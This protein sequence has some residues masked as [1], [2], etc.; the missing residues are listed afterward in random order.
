MSNDVIN[1]SLIK[2]SKILKVNRYKIGIV[3][4]VIP[5]QLEFNKSVFTRS[6]DAI[7]EETVKLNKMKVKTIIAVGYS[8]TELDKLIAYQCP[9]VDL[10]ICGNLNIL[11]MNTSKEDTISVNKA[12]TQIIKQ[13]NG[14][15]VPLV[16]TCCRTKYMGNVTIFIDTKTG[17]IHS[18]KGEQLLLNGP[19]S[20]INVSKITNYIESKFLSKV[21]ATEV[22]KERAEELVGETKTKLEARRE[23]CKRQE[24][25]F[26]SLLADSLIYHAVT[27]SKESWTN[28]AIAIVDS[29]SFHGTI[30][31]GKITMGVLHS[32]LENKYD[33]LKS[34][35]IK[36]QYLLEVFRYVARDWN[37]PKYAKFLQVSGARLKYDMRYK[38]KKR[39][40]FVK[41]RCSNC[42]VPRYEQLSMEKDY[43]VIITDSLRNGSFGYWWL[44]THT[45]DEY[46][47]NTDYISCLST[48]ISRRKIIYASVER[49]VE[50]IS[51]SAVFH[52]IFNWLLILNIIISSNF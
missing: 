13:A 22:D 37:N 12:Y 34:V 31:K 15:K 47:Y 49:R 6:I 29:S 50:V 44:Q 21:N 30:P 1:S 20:T 39:L 36:G 33:K 38:Y 46:L 43:T 5:E 28:V 48:Y 35:R 3:G 23:I 11:H 8:N 41:I 40:K 52:E 32:V 10:I 42:S 14:K 2:K 4:Y 24:C 26:G 16:T 9:L 45:K 17:N 51:K 7:N 19:I 27:T 25:N 18:W